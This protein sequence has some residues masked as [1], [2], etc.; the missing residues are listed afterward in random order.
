MIIQADG[1]EYWEMDQRL[2]DGEEDDESY[3][4]SDVG[5]TIHPHQPYSMNA[6]LVSKHSNVTTLDP[7]SSEDRHSCGQHSL[8]Q[9]DTSPQHQH[10][11]RNYQSSQQSYILDHSLEV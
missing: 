9:S 1:G 4:Y 6:S 5:T 2:P 3:L 10:D 11:D 7:S 8:S